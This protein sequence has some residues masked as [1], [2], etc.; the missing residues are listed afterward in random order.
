MVD[1]LPIVFG[2]AIPK[3]GSKLLFNVLRGLTKL[4]PF[5]DTGLN[6]IKPYFRDRPTSPAWIQQ[7]LDALKPGDIRF[8]YLYYSDSNVRKLC[9]E[10]WANFLII[11]DPRDQIV[12]EIY[13]AMQ[14]N[15]EHKL[16]DFFESSEGMESR[17]ATLI[18][19]I[20]EGELKRV[21]IR[22]HYER[23]IG[24]LDRSEV[25][26]V[27]F[28]DLVTEPR[29]NLGYVL[30]FLR[31]HGFEPMMPRDRAIEQLLGQMSPEKSVTFRKGTTGQWREYFSQENIDLFKNVAG[32]L[33][34]RLGYE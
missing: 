21:N 20:P 9:Q 26:V 18:N 14:I 28:E 34:L 11:R 31:D 15:P 23:F 17:I 30:D 13:Y 5:V 1:N 33:L 19:G 3:C 2:N 27:R 25:H 24:W 7:Q 32:D 8:G 29:E 22:Q 12:S 10:G 6:E 4:G 16:H